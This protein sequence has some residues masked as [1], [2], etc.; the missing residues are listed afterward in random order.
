MTSPR[1][2][3]IL[4]PAAGAGRAARRWGEWEARLRREKPGAKHTTSL[5]PG[6]ARQLAAE[7]ASQYD[8]IVAV[9]GDGTAF[10][11][12]S[13][14]LDAGATHVVLGIVPF[15]TGNDA[16]RLTGIRSP[17][18]ALRAL[19]G[20]R[21][22]AVDAVEVRCQ[23]GGKASVRHALVFASVGIVGELLK[24]TTP[25][26]KRLC[27]SRLAYA[28][29]LLRA[30]W[31]YRPAPM[32]VTCDEQVSAN[33]FLLVCASNGEHVGGGMRLA[34][35]ARSDDGLL[36][37][38]LIEAVGQ[39]EALRQVGRLCRGRHVGHPKVRYFTARTVAVETET[40][41]DVQADGESIGH[42]PARF[43]VRPGALRMLV[44]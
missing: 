16:A 41:V 35:G 23:V 12:A 21:T 22:R 11:V 15:G 24:Q 25:R 5:R 8:A 28:V 31:R 32:R 42:T 34:P 2:L 27:G 4:N 33:R 14:L 18:D 9:G 29:G 20:G 30:L 19:L 38:N 36:N 13:G 44:P 40:A 10:E 1:T 17:E 39:W 7:A 6:H 43:Q 26:V 37:L 3:F